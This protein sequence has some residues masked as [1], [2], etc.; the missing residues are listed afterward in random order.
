MP[1]V[2]KL[3]EKGAGKKARQRQDYRQKKK[4]EK[5]DL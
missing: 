3:Q 2:A 5:E 1:G 4:I